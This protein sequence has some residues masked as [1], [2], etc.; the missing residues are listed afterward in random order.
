VTVDRR[1]VR[2]AWDAAADD[3]AAARRRDGPDERLLDHLRE[4]LPAGARVL[5]VGCGDGRRTL[6][7]LDGPAV[8]LDFSRRQLELAGETVDAASLVQADMTA[9]PF[10]DDAFD[11]VTA[12][13]AVFHVPRSEHPGVY[14]EFA[15]VLR[16]GG[17]LLASVGSGRSESIRRDWLGSGVPMFWSTSGLEAARTHLREAGFEV[18]W[19]RAVD[20]PDGSLSRFVLAELSR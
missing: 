20:D 13:H 9:L 6:G 14:R 11:G 3:Y 1:A 19:Q 16:P 10:A 12:Y 2:R 8:G 7:N 15:R 17:V 4:R 18:L 5:D